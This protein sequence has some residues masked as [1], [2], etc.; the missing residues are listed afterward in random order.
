[1]V[2]VDGFG[3]GPRTSALWAFYG[4][5]PQKPVIDQ[6]TVGDYSGVDFISAPF[7]A[8]LTTADFHVKLKLSSKRLYGP[9]ESISFSGCI[10]RPDPSELLPRCAPKNH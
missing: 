9:D 6:Y 8:V 2:S 3:S 10:T 1:M 5:V 4:Q 7:C